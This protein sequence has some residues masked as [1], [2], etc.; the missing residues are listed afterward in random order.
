MPGLFGF[1]RDTEGE[2]SHLKRGLNLMCHELDNTIE[3]LIEGPEVFGGVVKNNSSIGQDASIKRSDLK[4]WIDGY[5][6]NEEDVRNIHKIE[7]SENFL[8][9]A[10]QRNKLEEVLHDLDGYFAAVMYDATKRCIL[11]FS[12]RLGFRP[13]Y[14]R[15]SG[16][17]FSWSTE[18]KGFFALPGFSPDYDKDAIKTFLTLGH[19][20]GDQSWFRDV[21]LIPPASI[22]TYSLSENS[23]QSHRYWSW[24]EIKPQKLSKDDAASQLAFLLQKAVAKRIFPKT[25]LGLML[26]GGLDSRTI[27]ACLPDG[28]KVD[29]INF[30]TPYSWDVKIAHD[31]HRETPF[32][33]HYHELNADNW[34]NGRK[35]AIWKTDGMKN[36]IHLH[37]SPFLHS[38]KNYDGVFDGILGGVLLGGIYLDKSPGII[39]QNF[40]KKLSNLNNVEA[41]LKYDFEK[42]GNIEAFIIENRIRRFSTLGGIS[43]YPSSTPLNPFADKDILEFVLSLPVHY[44]KF[45]ELFFNTIEKLNRDQYFKF[46]WQRTGLPIRLRTANKAI[47][48]FKIIQIIRMVGILSSYGFADYE[49]WKGKVELQNL[50][51]IELENMP[52]WLKKEAAQLKIPLGRKNE[53]R[54]FPIEK[55]SRILT[56]AF[57]IE[58]SN[59]KLEFP[60]T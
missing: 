29:L 35:E 1:V 38:F 18:L 40:I 57:W 59:K 27:L 28:V 54:N 44:R 52:D 3:D 22:L 37:L 55:L 36:M 15:H 4:I 16:N 45:N 14:Y 19:L 17:Q 10:Y 25:D 51:Q 24:E 49:K 39:F 48:K 13:I 46:P 20:V 33:L 47:Q 50:F 53:L 32:S 23:L 34:Y 21:K 5:W 42:K 26:S 2:T 30:G 43:F 8:I 7:K 58:Q 9:T 6:T 31:I 60:S 12:D 56:I 41:F 11:V